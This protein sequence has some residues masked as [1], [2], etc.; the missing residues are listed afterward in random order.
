MNADDLLPDL[1][2]APRPVHP[3]ALPD[4]ELLKSC[5]LTRGRGSGPGGQHR[6][7]V[8]T[9]VE[10]THR[11]TAI[12]AHAGERRSPEVNRKVALRRLRLALATEHREG[13]PEGEV[14]S[15]L[16]RTRVRGGKIILNTGHADYPAML[17][18][19]M[20]VLAACSWDPKWA[21]KR[22]ACTPSQLIK[23]IAAHP[24]ALLVLNE[25]RAERGDHPVK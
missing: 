1:P 21:G 15:E 3:A 25:R 24:P 6:N 20:D 22:L 4:D 11:P 16:W 7:K 12:A 19:A 23:L 2:R 9:L 14:R 8:Q 10:L 17:A 5:T 13:V 18:E